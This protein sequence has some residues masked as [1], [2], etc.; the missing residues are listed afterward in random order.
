MWIRGPEEGAQS[1]DWPNGLIIIIIIITIII[2]LTIKSVTNRPVTNLTES[3]RDG[4]PEITTNELHAHLCSGCVF[5]ADPKNQ[6]W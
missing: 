5:L 6:G 4:L 3:T 1:P 2:L